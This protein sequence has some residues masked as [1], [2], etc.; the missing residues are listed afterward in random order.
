MSTH[1]L[2]NLSLLELKALL[3]S[4]ELSASALMESTLERIHSTHDALNAV[5]SLRPPEELAAEALE[6]DRRLAEGE[7]G[8]LEGIPLGVK[9]LEDVE[10]MITTFGS[11]P[12]REN[13][14]DSDSTQVARLRRA[15]AIP[16]AKTN[17][18]EFGFTAITKNLLFGDT[19]SPWDLS[20]SPGG[21]SGG[22]AA[23]MTA[24]V[25][26]LVTA[27]DGGGSI[28]IPASFVGAFGLKTSQ[29][30]VPRGPF[31][32]W[33]TSKT[34]VYG[35]LTKT[36]ADAAFFLDVVCGLSIDDPESL[37]T[38][39]TSYVEQLKK[40]LAQPLRIA[41]SRDLGFAVVQ[42]DIAAAV[43]DSVNVLAG[44]GHEVTEIQGGPG[45]LGEIWKKLGDFNLAGIFAPHLAD[46]EENITRALM[47]GVREATSMTAAEWE[48]GQTQRG[49]LVAW[50]NDLF[51]EYDLLV[52]PTVAIDPPPSRGPF[53]TETDGRPQ[54]PVVAG[55]FTI[56]F[57]LSWNPAATVR[58]GLSKAGLPIGMQIV[59]PRQRDD[60]VLQISKAFEDERPWHPDWPTEL[61]G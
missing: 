38:P 45:Q 3:E 34:S 15:G 7:A 29:G 19:R 32:R 49:Q 53:P 28:R 31:K 1:D 44:L 41:Y 58:A 4:G 30:R 9:D 16:V 40:S 27:S 8:P 61:A 48:A 25:L 24:G 35:P 17:T 23:L 46:H 6:A 22:S 33:D 50:C 57:N 21:S 42:S 13:R 52:T 36:V 54:I 51:R 55:A 39:T 10:G 56:P 20:R 60:L 59:G 5:V 2:P 14:A 37:P 12:F 26:P 18:P 47:A 43:E 11:V